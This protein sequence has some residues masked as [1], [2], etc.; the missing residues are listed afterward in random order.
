MIT[1]TLYP[2]E[3]GEGFDY[4]EQI[5]EKDII[6]TL[7]ELTRT[8]R[9]MIYIND[10]VKLVIKDEVYT[11]MLIKVSMQHKCVSALRL[12]CQIENMEKRVLQ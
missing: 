2:K 8:E 11:C 5:S 3:T 4:W 10:F 6:V 7:F 12:H 9:Q 1:I